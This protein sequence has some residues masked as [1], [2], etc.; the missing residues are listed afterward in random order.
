MDKTDVQVE[1]KDTRSRHQVMIEQFNRKNQSLGRKGWEGIKETNNIMR[2]IQTSMDLSG[3]GRQGGPLALANPT[4]VP[5]AI[6]EMIQAIKSEHGY[7]RNQMQIRNR[8]NARDYELGELEF[9][10][11]NADPTRQEES[12]AG[13]FTGKIHGVAASARA[14]NGFLNRLRRIDPLAGLSQSAVM[15]WRLLTGEAKS[16]GTGEVK[17]LRGPGHKFKDPTSIKVAGQFVRNKLTPLAGEVSDFLAPELTPPGEGKG[18]LNQMTGRQ[19]G[20]LG[21]AIRQA[22]K[23]L[24]LTFGDIYDAFKEHGYTRASVISLLATLGWGSQVHD[25]EHK[26]K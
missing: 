18:P 11:H 6:K 3:V 7:E 9:T 10:D 25:N 24:P 16:P 13:R 22:D 5:A 26:K 23:P 15:P 4:K 12:I 2:L 8:K 1:L 14:F 19:K 21:W 17:D 20:T